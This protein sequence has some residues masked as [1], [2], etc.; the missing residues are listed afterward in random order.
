MKRNLSK[1]TF[2]RM[3]GDTGKM[4]VIRKGVE[5]VHWN[6]HE[7]TDEITLVRVNAVK[8]M[9]EEERRYGQTL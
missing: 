9:D 4:N 5:L 7:N 8:A 1:V 3:T 6:N 2:Y